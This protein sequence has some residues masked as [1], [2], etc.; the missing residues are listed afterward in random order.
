M[1]FSFVSS[2]YNHNS[3]S[4]RSAHFEDVCK[5]CAH[6]A[7]ELRMI[8]YSPI[9]HWHPIAAIYDLPKGHEYWK[10]A[11]ETMLS[12]AREMIIIH[13]EGTEESAG[14]ENETRFCNQNNI[15]IRH[16]S[17]KKMEFV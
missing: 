1:D 10:E 5:V 17:L 12:K 9:V 7:A 11:D 14:I 16:F 4:V 2:P 13:M 3:V 8:V 15:P 6:F